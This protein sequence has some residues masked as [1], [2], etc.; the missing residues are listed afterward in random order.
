MP[1]SVEYAPTLLALAAINWRGDD[2]ATRD[3]HAERVL[4]MGPAAELV[5]ESHLVL[6]SLHRQL[7]T[8]ETAQARATEAR[9]LAER[10]GSPRLVGLAH[11]AMARAEAASHDLSAAA[12]SFEHAVGRLQEART[13]FE[14]A[15]ALRSYAT[16]VYAERDVE[17]A[18]TLLDEALGLLRVLGAAPAA[19]RCQALLDAL[20]P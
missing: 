1:R 18:R 8:L 5:V 10:L 7:G 15:S 4:A 13:P 16:D 2:L 9:S 3:R 6:A 12:S 17:R 14:R 11:L 20:V 19:G